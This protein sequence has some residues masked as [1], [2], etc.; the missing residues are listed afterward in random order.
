MGIL[1]FWDGGQRL[2]LLETMVGWADQAVEG[3]NG[4]GNDVGLWR[5]R[6]GDMMVAYGDVV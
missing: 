4:S 2:L 1:E 6:F 3:V 5:L